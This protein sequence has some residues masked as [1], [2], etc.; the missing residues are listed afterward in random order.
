MR[1]EN[2]TSVFM[3]PKYGPEVAGRMCSTRFDH[4]QWRCLR[5][6][7]RYIWGEGDN[8][9]APFILFTGKSSVISEPGGLL[10]DRSRRNYPLAR[11]VV[12]RNLESQ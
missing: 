7:V 6:T 10:Q 9:G 11:E 3:I 12:M 1:S 4:W 8:D 5:P 2:I